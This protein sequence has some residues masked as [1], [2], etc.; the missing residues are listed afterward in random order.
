MAKNSPP[1]GSVPPAQQLLR[2]SVFAADD[3]HGDGYLDE[4]E[5][6]AALRDLDCELEAGASASLL[7]RYGARVDLTQFLEL[8]EALAP[9]DVWLAFRESDAGRNG[10][11]DSAGLREALGRLD[12]DVDYEYAEG[13]LERYG[14]GPHTVELPHPCTFHYVHC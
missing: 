6:T 3:L 2:R 11:L 14:P 8:V 10:R 9:A 7:Q 1:R 5:L 13:L 4:A 12:C